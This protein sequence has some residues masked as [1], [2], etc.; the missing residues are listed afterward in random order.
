MLASSF[1]SSRGRR[2]ARFV[3]VVCLAT[4]LPVHAA[5]RTPMRID[6]PEFWPFF[7]RDAAGR[8]TGFFYEVVGE[9]LHRMGVEAVWHVCPWGRC[10]ENVRTGEAD[11]MITVPTAERLAYAETHQDPFH[12]KQLVV[13]TSAGHPRRAEVEA[14]ACIDDIRDAGFS[15]I[16]Y[17]G[18]G[19][20]DENI[21]A[22][23]IRTY[24]VPYLRNVWLML[25]QGRGDIVI[26]WPGGAWPDIVDQG[27]EDDIVQTGV[28]LEC[29][30]FHLLIGTASPHVGLLPRFNETILQMQRDGTID[31]IVESYADRLD[32]IRP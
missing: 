17:V 4:L 20:N 31:R 14:L 6:Y 27:L 5:A 28:V 21:R 10:Q 23:G 7:A 16:T 30:P 13:F 19:W 26:E 25:A 3:A 2:I 1:S 15:V 9:A 18:N 29:M 32:R 24:E 12:R 11:A 8:M 22:R